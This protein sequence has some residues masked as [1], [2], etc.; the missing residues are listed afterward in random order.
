MNI[1]QIVE[2]SLVVTIVALL[3]LAMKRLFHDKLD[4]RWHYFIWMVL[5]V[6]MIV[7]LELEWLKSPLSLF[8]A[9]PVNYWTRLWELKSSRAG[10]AKAAQAIMPW[11]LA[12]AAIV[13]SYYLVIAVMIRVR[14]IRLKTAEPATYERVVAIACKYGL[15]PCKRI[16]IAHKGSPYVC[17]LIRPILVLTMQEDSELTFSEQVIVHELL[18][19]KHGDVLINYVL[20]LVR[21]VNWFNPLIWYVTAVILN[22]SEALCD[23]RVLELMRDHSAAKA[24]ETDEAM[25]TS[26]SMNRSD[27]I[28]V[29]SKM[30]G[31]MEAPEA[32]EKSYGNLLIRMA[33]KKSMHSA[34]IGTTN[35]ANS[36]RSMRIRIKRIADFSR[37]PSKVGFVALCITIILSVSSIA[38][39]DGKNIISSGVKDEKNLNRVLLRAQLYEAKTPEEAIY[40]YLKALKDMNPV[41]LMAVMPEEEI[42]IYEEWII[43]MYRSDRFIHSS[44]GTVVEK[45]WINY[46]WEMKEHSDFS[47]NPWFTKNGDRMRFCNIYGLKWEESEGTAVAK[48]TIDEPDEED[49]TFLWWELQLIKEDGWKVRRAREYVGEDAYAPQPVIAASGQSGDWMVCVEGRNEASFS[50]IFQSNTGWQ[51][52]S[53]GQRPTEETIEYPKQFEMIYKVKELYVT[54]LGDE[55]LYDTTVEVILK[56]FTQ[57][58]YEE[59]ADEGLP[60]EQFASKKYSLQELVAYGVLETKSSWQELARMSGDKVMDEA[61]TVDEHNVGG[62]TVDEHIAGGYISSSTGAAYS[63]YDGSKLESGRKMLLSGGGTGYASWEE[64]D[65][66]HFIAWIYYNGECVEVIV[67]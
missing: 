54:Y 32:M 20:H 52:Y 41:Y 59:L 7:P 40:L 62:M 9:I 36:Y 57:E 42:P 13:A 6:R 19:K 30:P 56:S 46:N 26:E 53:N 64:T 51:F 50:S 11:Y 27:T 4:A 1:W 47:Q 38:Y 65:T 43:N 67:Q 49:D 10:L 28:E 17:G 23:Q 21:V 60:L 2:Y 44:D 29:P 34:R 61:M 5:A 25:E 24:G 14:S 8:E 48:L 55:P 33:E 12:G 39:C 58:E 66:L 22:D 31:T 18:H 3:L 45:H 35:M 16:K 37:V 15:K 63:R